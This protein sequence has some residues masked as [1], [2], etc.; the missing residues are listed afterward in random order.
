M[1][2][3]STMVH[4]WIRNIL[5]DGVTSGWY[6]ADNTFQK[7][8]FRLLSPITSLMTND[9]RMI[10]HWVFIPWLQQELNAYRD[11]INNTAKQHDR[12]KVS[13]QLC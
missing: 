5:D 3:T 4:S 1:V 11:H 9:Y 13:E 6:D 10:F 2:P 7:S 8:C 12:N